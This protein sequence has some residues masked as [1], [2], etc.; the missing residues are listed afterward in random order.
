MSSLALYLALYP[1][2]SPSPLP[3][4]PGLF[5]QNFVETLFVLNNYSE[6]PCYAA[7]AAGRVDAGGGI[8]MEGIDLGGDSPSQVR[9][10][11]ESLRA[12]SWCIVVHVYTGGRYLGLVRGR[13]HKDP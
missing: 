8:T 9:R 13:G 11:G 12:S 10:M 6:H 1:Y 5:A 2:L 4:T 3:Q 7:A